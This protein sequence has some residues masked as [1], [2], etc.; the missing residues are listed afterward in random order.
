MKSV[1]RGALLVA[2]LVLLQACATGYGKAGFTGGYSDK[3]IDATHY[4]VEFDGNGHTS[5]ERVWYFWIYRCAELTRENGFAYFSVDTKAGPQN[6][7]YTPETDEGRLQPAVLS[8]E[9][10]DHFIEVRSSG[11]TSFIYVPGATITR[12]HSHAVVSMYNDDVPERVA[13]LRAQSVL[14]LLGP[15]V[16][17]NGKSVAPTRESI[18]EE[19]AFALSP[20]RVIVNLHQYM[21][22]H[23]Q[24]PRTSPFFRGPSQPAQAVPP[25][26]AAPKQST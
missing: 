13:F 4:F 15:Y 7:S 3:K 8:D 24:R 2:V 26:L 11:G 1:V 5:E 17:T 22:A 9:D 20:G 10:N 21:L 14:D 16:K 18:L 23:P 19:S 6:S 25:F 12:W